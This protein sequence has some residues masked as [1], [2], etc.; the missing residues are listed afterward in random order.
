MVSWPQ[1]ALDRDGTRADF[2]PKEHYPM[3]DWDGHLTLSNM[4][5]VR[6]GD[7]DFIAGF[8]RG[9]L[10]AFKA[11]AWWEPRDIEPNSLQKV[12][13][14]LGKVPTRPFPAGEEIDP[15][16]SGYL[17]EL[18]RLTRPLTGHPPDLD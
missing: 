13:G 14:A 9:R 17:N 11:R 1:Y 2:A 4:I 12:K 10:D 6:T 8:A 18:D 15:L 3:A 5:T 7:S 16:P